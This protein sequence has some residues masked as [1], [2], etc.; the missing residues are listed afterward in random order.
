MEYSEASNFLTST[1]DTNPKLEFQLSLPSSNAD[2]D[3]DLTLELPKKL[4]K[5]QL[6]LKEGGREDEEVAPVTV[7][8]EEVHEELGKQ[9]HLKEYE[10][11]KHLI[12]LNQNEDFK[13]VESSGREEEHNRI[14]KEDND[15]DNDGVEEEDERSNGDTR[16]QY[17]VR[18]E[19]EDCSYYMKTGTC[20]FGFNCKFNHPVRRKNQA[21]REKVKESEEP[22]ESP[23]QTECKYYL[24][25]GGC[26][27]GK[28]C[29]YN[30][31]REKPPMLPAKT[32]V[33]PVYDFNFLG[34]PI[35]PGEKE[36]P[37]YMR[38]GSCKYGANCRFN[39]P[40]PTTV[41]SDPP[42]A[43]NN[44][45]SAALQSSSQSSVATW[46]SPRGLNENAPFVPI[47][48][49]ATQGVTSQNP[50]WNGYQAPIYSPERSIHLAPAY[51]ISNPA[52]DNNV[53]AHQQH[54]LVDEFPE[55]PGQ[56]ECNYYMKTG[57]CKFKSNCKYHH[58]KNQ[59]P[60]SSP[61][62]LS[63]KGLPLRPGQHVCSYYSRYGI[64]KFGPACKFD[65]PTQPALMTGYAE[66]QTRTSETGNESDTA[67]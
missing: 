26:K 27:Y 49:S 21:T 64:C 47:M 15:N 62:A 10:D 5:K 16:H 6:Y 22:T 18:P 38:N 14:N 2:I 42:S 17:P 13:S 24:R 39:H 52:T 11:D 55:R 31:S 9:L 51:V 28:A 19:A 25:T 32:T 40:D 30:H 65:H 4:E 43:F 36:C 66:D 1:A 12:E 8:V 34:L 20:K 63:D 29:R 50:E 7:E 48:F 61:C 53:Y 37:Y 35:R 33:S 45:G 3:S 57:D 41:G 44:G 58:P 59:I 46:S 60:K 54:T 56:P 23:G 67:I